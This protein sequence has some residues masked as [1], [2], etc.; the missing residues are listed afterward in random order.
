VVINSPETVKGD[1]KDQN[2]WNGTVEERE[3]GVMQNEINESSE[4]LHEEYYSS[5]HAVVVE[6]QRG[7][8]L[9]YVDDFKDGTIY[10]IDGVGYNSHESL[11]FKWGMAMKKLGFPES[12]SILGANLYHLGAWTTD[13]QLPKEQQRYTRAG[14]INE[15]NHNKSISRGWNL[16]ASFWSN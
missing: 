3:L 16:G 6:S 1:L 5:N 13:Q 4:I 8:E 11:N 12:A 7:G 15:K 14:P 9:D 10:I 2:A